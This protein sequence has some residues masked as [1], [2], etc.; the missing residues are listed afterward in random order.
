VFLEQTVQNLNEHMRGQ[1]THDASRNISNLKYISV[2]ACASA[3]GES[4]IPGII[5]S[6]D[7]LSV[8]E[9]LKKHGVRFGTDLIMKSNAKP[10]VSAGIFLDHVQTVFLPNLAEL[11]RLDEFAEEMAVLLMDNCRSHITCIV[12]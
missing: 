2:I 3:A 5:T 1:T 8:R 7:S 11:R 4:L 9:Q 12:M 10:Y 6:Q